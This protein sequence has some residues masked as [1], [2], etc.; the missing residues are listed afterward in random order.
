[1]KL[2]LLLL[3]MS[4]HLATATSYGQKINLDRRQV[5]LKEAFREIRKQSGFNIL[6]NAELLKST[7]PVD[8]S[9]KDASITEALNK[10]LEGQHLSYEIISNNVIIKKVISEIV[11][12]QDRLVKGI[13]Q[14][15]NNQPIR[16]ASITLKENPQRATKTNERGEFS[17]MVPSVATL[18][19]SF[20]G[21]S[22][23]ELPLTNESEVIITLNEEEAKLDEVVVVGYGTQKKSSVTA[24][25]S[26]VSGETLKK[27]GPVANVSNALG[28]N[29]SGLITRQTTGEP[30]ADASAVLLRGNA[31]L[32]LVDGVERNWNRINMQ[33]IE[34][35]SI[36]K[37]A[38]AV[39]PYGLR[40]ANGVILVTTKRGK[41][42][43]M[44]LNYSGEY[45][46]QEP[47]NTP[48]FMN[49][50]D[51]LSLRNQALIMDGRPNE[52]IADDVLELY[53]QGTDRYPNT[54]WVSAYLRSSRTQNHNLSLNG[55]S[56]NI[57]AF[58]SM[59]YFYQGSMYGDNQDLNRYNVRSNLDI[60]ATPTTQLSVDISLIGDEKK[61]NLLNS[62][63][64]MLN[65]YRLRATDP[66]VFSNG[67]PAFQTSIGGSM[68]NLVHGGG[69]KSDKNNNQSL[70]LSLK[71]EIPFIP[72][73]SV[74]GFYNYDRQAWDNKYWTEPVISYNYNDATGEYIEDNAW[75]R[76]K[77]NL[78]QG[79]RT[80]TYQTAQGFINYAKNFN[81]HNVTAIA[82]YERRW[83]IRNEYT[84]SRR[85]YD[86]TIP[87][88][89]MGSP[90]KEFQANSGTSYSTAQDGFIFRANYDF[91]QKYLFEFASRYD[92][93]YKYAPDR[94]SALFPSASIGWRPS[95]E[96]FFQVP[97]IDD[98]KIRASYGKSGNP[99]G[100][101]FA[102]IQQY[103]IRNSAI[104][105]TNPI[106]EQGVYEGVEPNTRL[107]WETVW[108]A[109]VALNLTM[110]KGWLDVE[111][112]A[113]RDLRGDM[114]LAPDAVVP[115]EYGIGL[116]DENAG[117]NERYGFETTLS[118]QGAIG[119]LQMRH[120][121]IF[122]FTRDKRLEI[123]EAAGTY[124][125]PRFR[126]T[127]LPTGQLRG[128]K[129]AGL[130]QDQDDIDNWAFQNA[131][132]LPG[133]IKYVDI[134]GD[135]K[136]NSEDQVVIG[137]TRVPEIM[138]GYT[139]G[140]DY[141]RFD[142]NVFIQGTGNSS[143]YLGQDNQ[144]SADRGVRFPFDNDKPRADHINSWTLDNPDPNAQYPRLSYTKRTHNY[145]L[146]D[147]WVVNS[148]FVRL[149]SVQLGYTFD[150]ELSQKAFI[151]NLRLYVNLYN[152]LI[153]YSKLPRDFDVETQ[154]YNSYP[155]Q[156]ITSFGL[157]ATF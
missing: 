17:L 117:K 25:V 112:D 54:D 46:I 102:F 97:S 32:V 84:A 119:N 85:E 24:A 153:I 126:Q 100:G 110:W 26:T 91:D 92:R 16:G 143:Y 144:G 156:F 38:S 23:Q 129:S 152:P 28:G 49:A 93:S 41:S 96:S 77:P 29:V 40:G 122:S 35:I 107:T 62:N 98:L 51:G 52:V 113:Y 146:S 34:T 45:G 57:K 125:I 39:A 14:D 80:F 70:V 33:D 30:G 141:K 73:L 42:G 36:L 7:R 4:I 21:F 66:D 116:A 154:G 128:Y 145:E 50:Y 120:T 56:E 68:W 11:S 109:N 60:N 78:S 61:S 64:I 65:V 142:L 108:K 88:L 12:R 5:P 121:A 127:G 20:I 82:V 111:L 13:V 99:V 148:S 2:T 1:M 132:T 58:V 138:W 89:D 71:Q 67:L 105:G 3:V 157:N 114:I 59:G 137:K 74:R 95:A 76:S 69:D 55:G 86:F 6:I 104:W 10:C 140:L 134:N 139:L 124:N 48:E 150:P 79:N 135:G 118:S 151:K 94:R 31:P 72:G 136:I 149:K 87:E 155:Q 15:V 63:D 101:D 18:T 81:K 75:L 22:R 47:T 43:T 115:E 130:F 133:D 147:F 131:S 106:Q 53:R 103:L 37:D 27:V 9:L 83:G 19:I 44:V 90:N 8:L 123:R